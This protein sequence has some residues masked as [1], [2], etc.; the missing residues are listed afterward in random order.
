MVK[1]TL[2][3]GTI[4]IHLEK[5]SEFTKPI[6]HNTVTQVCIPHGVYGYSNNTYIV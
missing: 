3:H 6:L 5:L 1:K 2:D 4:V